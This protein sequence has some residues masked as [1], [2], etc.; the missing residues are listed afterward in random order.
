MRLYLGASAF[1]LVMAASVV[2]PTA[3]PRQPPPRLA[4]MLQK[5]ER[6]GA[7]RVIVGVESP[8]TPEGRLDLPA[9]AMQ[10]AAISLAQDGVLNRLAGVQVDVVR[11]FTS[12]P[13]FAARVGRPAL[14]QL[15]A[16]PDVTSLH[17]DL[18][19]RP[20]LAQSAALIGATAAWSSGYTGTGWAVAIIDTG[21]DL[22]HPFFAGKIVS[23]ACYSNAGGFGGG[24]SLCPGGVPSS[25]GAGAGNHCPLTYSDC[26]H[27]THV[28]GIAAGH[29]Y[30]GGPAINGI[31]QLASIIAIQAFTGF[32]ATSCGGAACVL[33]FQS[34]QIAA[35]QR[36]FDLR[37]TFTI[38]AVNMSLGGGEYFDQATCDANNTA[39][40][41]I[42]D[43]L[44]SVGIATVAAAGNAGEESGISAPAC[45]ST[46][47]SVG[48][49]DDGSSGTIANRVSS[50]SNSAPF[51]SLLAPGSII[52]SAV[53]NGFGDASGT[54]MATPHVAGA[55]AL[56]RQRK[57]LASVTEILESLV[58]TGQPIS[59]WRSG[60]IR[61][62]VNVAAAINDLRV[63]YMSLDTPVRNTTV[64]QP[65]AVSG[66]AL[67]MS[68]RP[69]AGTGVD[70]V[71]VWAFPAAGSP[72]PIGV[73][74]YG[75]PRDDVAAAY[76]AQ[77]R[78][79]GWS[80]TGRG[81][82]PGVYTLAAYA[83]STTTGQFSQYAL[84]EG[85]SIQAD[86]RLRIESPTGGAVVGQPFSLSGW[87]VDR[88]A[89]SGTGIDTI[90]V[91]A[92]RNPGSGE[93]PVF[94]GVPAY[95]QS[96]PDIA[97]QFG[98]QFANSGFSLQ[99]STLPAGRYLLAVYGRSSV[100]KTFS[101]VD[102]VVIDISG[103]S[104]S[105]DT[106]PNGSTRAQPFA[107]SGWAIDQ[108]AASGTGI[109]SVH[110]WAYP[111]PGSGA[112]PTFVGLATYGAARQDIA[113]QFGARYLNSGF[114]IT[115]SGLPAGH[116]YLFAI[117]P[118]ST[119]SGQFILRTVDVIVP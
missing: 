102:T 47:V 55:W 114:S 45:I 111:D 28:A 99:I 48:S 85:L 82:P 95:G 20:L 100:S 77:F 65:F 115:V 81:L 46:A 50:F 76:G 80:I 27:G 89:G 101:V 66:W 39:R 18:P 37:N 119:A 32:E 23:Q 17:E 103:G 9:A 96:R 33:S 63:D 68:V 49:V 91:W 41:A 90:H 40:K 107:I 7:I 71:H 105:I 35:L 54:S 36:V 10:R 22:D 86:P 26:F 78:N 44:R 21:V 13:F 88:A 73:A 11:R 118:H 97:S 19:E 84:A 31:G 25:T 62:R 42:I 3:Q 104:A 38:A 12:I 29:Q 94:V 57:P 117:F 16:M 53:P 92:Y 58:R 110:V 75:S 83:H 108:T 113:N 70:T 60:L 109:D 67:N 24:N 2:V 5:A 43:Q 116:R 98:A 14:E 34:D 56:L 61:P 79:T 30:S 93:A 8:F 1:C 72:I 74:Q 15:A 64:T 51:L 69:S 87:A 4:A 6:D 106:P 52:T 112:A 59:D